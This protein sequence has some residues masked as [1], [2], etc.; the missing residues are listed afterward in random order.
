VVEI[1]EAKLGINSVTLAT[2]FAVYVPNQTKS[3]FLQV[4]RRKVRGT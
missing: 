3:S 1:S 2:L 4:E